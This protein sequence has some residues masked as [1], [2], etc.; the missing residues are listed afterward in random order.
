[1]LKCVL[2]LICKSMIYTVSH[3]NGGVSLLYGDVHSYVISRKLEHWNAWGKFRLL[4]RGFPS[5]GRLQKLCGTAVHRMD[6][7]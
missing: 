2:S 7:L 5:E 3:E 6:G 1:V 4:A